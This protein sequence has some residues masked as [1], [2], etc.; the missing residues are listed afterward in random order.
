MALI[1]MGDK[2]YVAEPNDPCRKEGTVL[3][4]LAENS[5]VVVCNGKRI[6]KHAGQLCKR[7][8]VADMESPNEC[9]GSSLPTSCSGVR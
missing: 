5:Y 8:G 9:Y 4:Q 3:E 7:W 6:H 2:V 1:C